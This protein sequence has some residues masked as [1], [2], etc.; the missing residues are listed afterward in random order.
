MYTLSFRSDW[1]AMII[2]EYRNWETYAQ[3]PTCSVLPKT[4]QLKEEAY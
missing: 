2:T 3:H 4:I 1:E